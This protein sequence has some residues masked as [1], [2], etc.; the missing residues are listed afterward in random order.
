M[1][2]SKLLDELKKMNKLLDNIDKNVSNLL[3]PEV[4]TLRTTLNDLNHRVVQIE[5]DKKSDLSP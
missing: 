3:V 4:I 5:R 1:D 2:E